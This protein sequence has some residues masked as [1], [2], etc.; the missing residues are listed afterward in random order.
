MYYSAQV[1]FQP[2]NQRISNLI[3]A[4]TQLKK[5]VVLAL[6]ARD[7]RTNPNS[8]QAVQEV[9]NDALNNTVLVEVSRTRR[10]PIFNSSPP[11][12]PPPPIV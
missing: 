2:L 4:L 11:G 1:C 9:P 3:L 6:F 8:S 5:V 12:P 7:V 10:P